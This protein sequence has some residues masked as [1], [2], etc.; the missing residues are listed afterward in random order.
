MRKR[1]G[2]DEI[3]LLTVSTIEPRKNHILI[4]EA[5]E[6]ACDQGSKAIWCIVGKNGWKSEPLLKAISESKFRDRIKLTGFISNKE[7]EQHYADADAL[8]FASHHEG[9]G[10]PIAEALVREAPLVLLGTKIHR[11]V[12]GSCGRYFKNADELSGVIIALSALANPENSIEMKDKIEMFLDD[13]INVDK[14]MN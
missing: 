10:I 11:E 4:L 14:M 6:L 9:Y 3:R 13:R 5:F 8:V 12:A 1:K 2:S 7:L